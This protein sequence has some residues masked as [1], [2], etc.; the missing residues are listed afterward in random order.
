VDAVFGF[1]GRF[2]QPAGRGLDTLLHHLLVQQQAPAEVLLLH[3]AN[4]RYTYPGSGFLNEALEKVPF[5]ASFASL[6]DE[7]TAGA[8]LILP[9]HTYLER[10]RDDVPEPGTG[11]AIRTL[12][13]PVIKPRFDTR[14]P[15]DVLLEVARRLGGSVSEA[16]PWKDV[17]SLVQESFR[18]LHKVQKG[19]VVEDSFEAFWDEVKSKGGWWDAPASPSFT[20]Q[21]PSKKF[22]FP[23]PPSIPPAQ[24][25]TAAENTFPLL[26]NLY[27]SLAL[28]DGRGA[29][30]PWLQELPDPMTTV[31]W[32]SWV[33]LNPGTAAQ[34]G[35]Q[36][37]DAVVVETAQGKLEMPAYLYPGLRPEVIAIPLGQGHQVFGRYASGRGANPLLLAAASPFGGASLSAIPARIFPA[38]RKMALTRFG[39]E[40]RVHSQLPLKR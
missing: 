3:E 13:Q 35:I 27:A 14:D 32:G 1:A 22:R 38:G 40:G 37:G 28:T 36:Q 12:A 29:N 10:W 20:F 17:E 11:F 30:Q 18:P 6:M 24:A 19:S 26:L 34:L 33:E 2:E 16:L 31:M 4:P 21:T 8:D 9:S 5:I 23:G 25:G 39:G 7:T 15:G